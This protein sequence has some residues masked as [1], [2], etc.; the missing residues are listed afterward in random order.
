[1]CLL[2]LPSLSQGQGLQDLLAQL[3][4][5]DRTTRE[6]AFYQLRTFGYSSSDQI[7]VAIISLL[8]L[9]SASVQSQASPNEDYATYFGDVIHA[10]AALNDVRALSAL[11]AVVDSGDVA[12]NALAGF[13]TTA[14]DPVIT[15]LSSTRDTV[16]TAAV[17]VL[18]KMLEPPNFQLVNDPTSISKIRL[19]LEDASLDRNRFTRLSALEGLVKL[20]NVPISGQFAL[21]KIAIKPG[22][23]PAPINPTSQGVIPV[24]A[25]SSPSFD[26]RTLVE[27]SVK[28]GPGLVGGLKTGSVEDVNGDGLPDLVLHFPTQAAGFI[29]TDTAA[30]LVGKTTVGQSVVGADSVRILCH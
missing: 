29:C 6:Q 15:R 7:K 12:V 28:F 16:K 21:I 20:F 26:A 1:M 27:S 14:L 13:G 19:A 5:T 2:S 23:T 3:Q 24:A 17:L 22:S 10:V 4:S 25:L 11:L 30:I 9:E 8:T 18:D